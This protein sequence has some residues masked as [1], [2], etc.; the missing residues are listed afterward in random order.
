MRIG[1]KRQVSVGKTSLYCS[2]RRERNN[3]IAKLSDAKNKNSF[4]SI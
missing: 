3:R 2:H 4:F 1:K